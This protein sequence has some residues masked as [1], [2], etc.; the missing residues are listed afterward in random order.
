MYA[1]GLDNSQKS[2]YDSLEALATRS[3]YIGQVNTLIV[4]HGIVTG[5]VARTAH[6][7]NLVTQCCDAGIELLAVRFHTTG[8]IWYASSACNYD[9]HGSTVV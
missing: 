7:G 1:L 4:S 8:N 9:V 2:V 6:Y 5:N 3:K